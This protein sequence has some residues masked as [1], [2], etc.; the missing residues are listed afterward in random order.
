MA[1]NRIELSLESKNLLSKINKAGGDIDRAAYEAA[2]KGA[3]VYE[4]ALRAA[5]NTNRVPDSIT[6]HIESEVEQSGNRTTVAVGWRLSNYDPNNPSPG[7]KA[8]FLNYGTP[9]RTTNKGA[10]RGAIVGGGFIGR[11][12]KVSKGLIRQAQ[13]KF[14]NEVLKELK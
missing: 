2:Q 3:E 1:R 4:A 7:F 13:E 9:R 5:C 14:L 8:I 6:N 12:K 10:N 11:A